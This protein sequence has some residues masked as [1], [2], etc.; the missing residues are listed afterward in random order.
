[1]TLTKWDGFVVNVHVTTKRRLH[2]V[3]LN[4]ISAL[5]ISIDL[6]DVSTTKGVGQIN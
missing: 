1:M 3:T 6:L 5:T 4:P 2:L